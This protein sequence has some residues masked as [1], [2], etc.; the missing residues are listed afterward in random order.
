MPFQLQ[1]IGGALG[2]C[3]PMLHPHTGLRVMQYSALLRSHDQNIT[4]IVP[5]G[6]VAG[7]AVTAWTPLALLAAAGG[8][9]NFPSTLCCHLVQ[10]TP[11]VG[12]VRFRVKGVDQ[13]GD[14]QIE[15]T[16]SV[17]YTAKTNNFI[18][19]SKIFSRVLSIEFRSTGLDIASDTVRVGT[20]YD[21]VATSDGTNEDIAI[22]NN[23]VALFRWT[24]DHA[25]GALNPGTRKIAQLDPIDAFEVPVV[26]M[27]NITV[28][29]V[30]QHFVPIIGRVAAGAW[31][32]S[33]DKWAC[34]GG[35]TWGVT[36]IVQV[37]LLQHAK[38]IGFQR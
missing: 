25:Q 38:L 15:E 32:A 16:P 3:E 30:T 4:A 12:T 7:A 33:P 2:V 35:V 23:G 28:G 19:L 10:G 26:H 14:F 9:V 29:T 8:R 20:R 36:D 24:R 5:I 13:Y 34:P 37:S 17:S 1:S 21:W 18:Y 22:Q 27:Y 11:V 31:E 6:G